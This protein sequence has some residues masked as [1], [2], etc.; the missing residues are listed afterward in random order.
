MPKTTRSQMA[1]LRARIEMLEALVKAMQSAQQVSAYPKPYTPLPQPLTGTP[2]VWWG[3]SS[4]SSD[5]S[6]R[7]FG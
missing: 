5:L 4:S 3:Q 6:T 7:R 1:D 2:A